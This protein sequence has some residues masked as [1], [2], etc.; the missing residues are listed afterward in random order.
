MLNERKFAR[1]AELKQIQLFGMLWI[2]RLGWSLRAARIPEVSDPAKNGKPT[3]VTN[4]S[5]TLIFSEL[6]NR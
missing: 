2:L 6:K 1:S 3:T 4:L 5:L